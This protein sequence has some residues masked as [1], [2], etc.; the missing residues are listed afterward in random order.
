[1][2]DVMVMD[3]ASM[4]PVSKPP[5]AAM[6]A[7]VMTGGMV[8]SAMCQVRPADFRLCRP[9]FAAFPSQQMF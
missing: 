8:Q 3:L 7:Y 5:M 6:S 9:V 2:Q 4:A 1:M